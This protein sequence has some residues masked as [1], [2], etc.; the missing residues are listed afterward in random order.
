MNPIPWWEGL[1]GLSHGSFFRAIELPKKSS[2]QSETTCQTEDGN[3]PE[4]LSEMTVKIL[5]GEAFCYSP[6]LSWLLMAVA[7]WW[8]F[9]YNLDTTEG[10][11]TTVY[12][13]LIDRL[14][15]NLFLALG[16]I[17]FWH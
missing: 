1:G 13:A 2:S 9:P 3:A 5:T 4:N 14:A 15:I 6:N 8:V 10:G 12:D 11:N 17:G 16:Y 7:A